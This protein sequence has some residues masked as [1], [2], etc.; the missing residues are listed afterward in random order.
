MIRLVAEDP[1][2]TLDDQQATRITLWLQGLIP[3]ARCTIV[4]G[5][6]AEIIVADHHPTDLTPGLLRRIEEIA[7]GRFRQTEP[8][9]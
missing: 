6:L 4:R 8:T 2:L 7:R 3:A 9:T 5:P 1:L